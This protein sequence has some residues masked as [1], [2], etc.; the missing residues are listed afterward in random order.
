MRAHQRLVKIN[1]GACPFKAQHDNE[2]AIQPG[3]RP[4]VPA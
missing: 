4:T 3:K 2:Y 1:C